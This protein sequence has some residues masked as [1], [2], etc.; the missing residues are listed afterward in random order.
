VTQNP[1]SQSTQ[2]QITER[3]RLANS[4]YSTLRLSPAA[5]AREIRRAY[6]QLSKLYHPD[7][8]TLPEAEARS[9]FQRLNEAY[10][11]LG[12]PE[13]RSIYDLK[14][15]HLGNDVGETVVKIAELE[16][17][18][19]KIVNNSAYLDPNDRPLSAGEIS[20]IFFLG[21]TILGCLVLVIVVAYLRGVPL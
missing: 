19:P 15:G 6:R 21:L 1:H 2:K 5:S 12:N 17:N 8:T 14:I 10:A 18:K 9:K 16:V 7:T 11:T 3:T 13:R 20:V 4:Y